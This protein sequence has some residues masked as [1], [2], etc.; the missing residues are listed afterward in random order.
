MNSQAAKPEEYYILIIHDNG[1][2]RKLILVKD[3]YSIGRSLESDI[4]LN[5]QFVSRYH[6]TL[7]KCQTQ[8]GKFFYR[9]I[10][11]DSQGKASANGLLINGKKLAQKNLENGDKIVFAPQVNAIYQ[12]RK[13]DKFP[14]VNKHDPFDITLIDPAMTEENP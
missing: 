13:Y 4:Y 6:A 14:Q 3:I 9:I 12:H 11:G 2:T 10:D 8:A 5:S 1:G 7:Q